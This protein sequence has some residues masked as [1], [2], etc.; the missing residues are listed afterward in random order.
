MLF[1]KTDAA[2]RKGV[3]EQAK[4]WAPTLLRETVRDA[5]PGPET[6]LAK[7]GKVTVN[8]NGL[9]ARFG[10]TG[11]AVEVTGFEFGAYRNKYQ[12]YLSRHK[13]SGKAMQVTRRTT[14]Q[15]R[16]RNP[17]GWFLHPAAKR[18]TPVLVSRW[19]AALTKEFR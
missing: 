6:W 15:M 13:T 11:R 9:V 16:T 7:S 4:T 1:A 17:H 10:T 5:K 2:A 12:T 3:R 8:S 14:N 19:L 18:T